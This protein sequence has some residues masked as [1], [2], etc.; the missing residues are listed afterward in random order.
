MRIIAVTNQKGGCGKTTTAV[1]L[2]AVLAARG[3]RVLLIDL[4]PQAH[5]TVAL[6]LTLA[7]PSPTIDDVL[8]RGLPLRE[9][10]RHDHLPGLDVV[11][12]SIPLA[13]AEQVLSGSLGK[14][15]RLLESLR[16]IP[17]R[18]DYVLVDSPPSLGLLTFNALRAAD[19]AIV[20][21]DPSFLSVHGL[22]RLLEM[23]DLLR[24]EGRHS[25]SLKALLIMLD[26]RT[27]FAHELL[28][29]LHT[30]MKSR[31][32]TIIRQTVRLRE[33]AAC[34]KPVIAHAPGSG[35]AEDFERLTDE[36]IA[37]EVSASDVCPWQEE[38]F[39]AEDGVFFW[40]PRRVGEEVML[41]GDFNE[42]VPD[43]GV[44]SIPDAERT[45]K[46]IPMSPGCYRYRWVVD[47][48]WLEDSTNPDRVP[49]TV[50]GFDSVFEVGERRQLARVA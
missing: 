7:D 42:W 40:R 33:A 32:Q 49:S 35:A 12:S 5:A 36:V 37:E 31:Y 50:E 9:A 13:A 46:F 10:I 22:G 23:T 26:V 16:G 43:R 45:I 39:Q 1:N 15:R 27:C 41:A 4:D 17:K 19:E 30:A 28:C 18:Y 25:L 14:E 29:H 21:I 8:R 20:P 3:R 6:G 44:V 11:P 38:P 2:S 34:G 48:I 47:G 24:S